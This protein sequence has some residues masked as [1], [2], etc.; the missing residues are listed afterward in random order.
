MPLGLG[1][2]HLRSGHDVP[3]LRHVSS[4]KAAFANLRA[5]L[6]VPLKQTAVTAGMNRV[7]SSE[8]QV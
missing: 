8:Q 2:P 4:T 1:T 5:V 3:N 6:M 7:T